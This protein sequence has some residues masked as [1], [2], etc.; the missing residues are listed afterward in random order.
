[1][2]MRKRKGIEADS[3]CEKETVRQRATRQ[4][5]L[6]ICHVAGLVDHP[7]PVTLS[8]K[9]IEKEREIDREREEEGNRE[10]MQERERESVSQ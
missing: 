1:M 6:A 9:H 5:Q 3:D 8:H 7:S 4:L 2:T 10:S